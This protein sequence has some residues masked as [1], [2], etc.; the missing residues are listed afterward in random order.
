M[1]WSKVT[2]FYLLNSLL[3]SIQEGES[4]KILLFAIFENK[5]D[6]LYLGSTI[7]LKLQSGFFTKESVQCTLNIVHARAISWLTQVELRLCHKINDR[8]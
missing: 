6:H 1:R 3:N 8:S 7:S 5:F 2:L 4:R